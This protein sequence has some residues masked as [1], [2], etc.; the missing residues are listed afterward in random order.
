MADAGAIVEETVAIR[1]RSGDRFSVSC[2]IL[3]SMSMCQFNSSKLMFS[4]S[5]SMAC[6]TSCVSLCLPT[7]LV[8]FNLAGSNLLLCSSSPFL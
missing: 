4:V 2:T 5:A 1:V 8:L 3:I 6:C 7:P